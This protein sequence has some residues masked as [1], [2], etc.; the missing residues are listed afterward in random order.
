MSDLFYLNQLN[1]KKLTWRLRCGDLGG[2]TS[3]SNKVPKNELIDVGIILDTEFSGSITNDFTDGKTNALNDM[4]KST[5]ETAKSYSP[6]WNNAQGQNSIMNQLSKAAG[7]NVLGNVFNAIDSGI[8]SASST[9]D[10]VSKDY[11]G[12]KVTDA[13]NS[14]F[15]SAFDLVKSFHGTETSFSIPKLENTWISGIGPDGIKQNKIKDRLE[16]V[17]KHVSGDLK[18]AGKTFGLVSAPNGYVSD[19]AGLSHNPYFKGTYKLEIGEY[20]IHNLILKN[21]SYNLS[22]LDVIDDDDD[23]LYATVSYELIPAAY[24]SRTHLINIIQ[25]KK[26]YLDVQT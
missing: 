18:E 19:F 10:K 22:L 20:T 23:P 8:K 15:V 7:D 5:F 16:Y 4:V 12:I 17:L 25:R 6:F 24:V 14:G 1:N 26:D 2:E 21:F 11:L 9:I 13:L 3:E